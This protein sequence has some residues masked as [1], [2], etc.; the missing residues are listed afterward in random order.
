MAIDRIPERQLVLPALYVLNQQ[1][2]ACD[3]TVPIQQLRALL[4]P[5]GEDWE[6]LSGRADDRFSQKV[7]NL[8]SHDTLARNN[9]ATHRDGRFAITGA[10]QAFL[11]KHLEGLDDLLGLGYRYDDIIDIIDGAMDTPTAP[12]AIVPEI[13]EG[14]LRIT[15]RIMRTRSQK[16]RQPA[17]DRYA[18]NGVICCCIRAF[19]CEQS[20]GNLGRGFIEFH[21][22]NPIAHYEEH[23]FSKTIAGAL[24]NIAPLC[25]NCHRMIHRGAPNPALSIAELQ[26]HHMR[27]L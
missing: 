24:E 1:G 3:T 26:A 22:I 18:I 4:N 13:V 17:F 10:G 21:H 14:G 20:D 27:S 12:I 2:G 7:R 23:D 19:D 5:T 15:S 9:W 11:E 16:L 25:A 8:K 6:R